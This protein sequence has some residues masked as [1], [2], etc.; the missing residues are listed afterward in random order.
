MGYKAITLVK[1]PEGEITPDIFEVVEREVPE[2]AEGQIHVRQTHMSLDPAM[3][4]WMNDDRGSYLPPVEIGAVM[5]ANGIG[6]VVAS[7]FE[8]LSP[9]DRVWGGFGWAEEAV[10]HGATALPVPAGVDADA[11]MCV[12]AIP[13]LTAAYGLFEIGEPK[14]GETILITGAAGSVGTLVGQMAKAEGLRVIGVS[15]SDDKRRWME[16]TLGFDATLN[17]KDPNLYKALI[18]AAPDGI[19]VF[20]E[21][22]GGPIQSMAMTCMN[23]FGRVIVCGVISDYNKS[24]PSPGPSWVHLVRKRVKVQGF[25]LPDHAAKFPAL[26]QRLI[27]YLQGGH[28]QYRAHTLEGLES[29]IEGINLLFSGGNNGKL[30][31]AL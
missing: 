23:P 16:E 3:R 6:E 30:M 31:V 10:V 21:N 20:F 15:G 26:Q 29:A 9:G 11:F 17:Y 27:G 14:A 25:T 4:G 19:D 22:T 2:L 12:L 8:G 1:R 5:R 24:T 13:G 28:I 18:A 7:R